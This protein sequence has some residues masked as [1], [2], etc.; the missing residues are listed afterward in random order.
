MAFEETAD[1]EQKKQDRSTDKIIYCCTKLGIDRL[2]V[3]KVGSVSIHNRNLQVLV[4]EMF[5]INRGISSS[6]KKG[7]FELK[8]EHPYNLRCVS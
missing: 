3:E 5:K 2:Q 6:I 7:M 8:A 1:L 4:T